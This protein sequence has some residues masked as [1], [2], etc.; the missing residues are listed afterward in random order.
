MQGYMGVKIRDYN[1][2]LRV[3]E[4]FLDG[5]ELCVQRREGN[6]RR[7]VQVEETTY[8]K[9]LRKGDGVSAKS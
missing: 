9:F 1:P 8:T 2:V 3:R 4:D 5:I 7:M 6:V